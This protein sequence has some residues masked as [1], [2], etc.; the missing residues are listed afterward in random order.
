MIFK[1][2][3]LFI[4][5]TWGFVSPAAI[6]VVTTLPD[7]AWTVK[8][9]GKAHVET[10]SLLTGNEDPHFV[11]ATPSFVSKVAGADVVC[12]V[13]LDLEI[14]WI[15]KVLSRSG[16][17]SVQPGGQGYCEVASSIKTPLEI[18][19]VAVDR[20]MGDVHP[21]GNPHFWLSPPEAI[22]GANAIAASLK[23]ADPSH[24]TEFDEGLK[25][26]QDQLRL[27][28]QSTLTRLSKLTK[29]PLRVLQYHRELTYFLKA[30]GIQDYGSLE[31]LP[32]VLP[33]AGRIATVAKQAKANAIDVLVAGPLAPKSLLQKFTEL[34]GVPHVVVPLSIGSAMDFQELQNTL[35]DRIAQA[36]APAKST[37]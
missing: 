25:S 35:I 7:L 1:R 27:I 11:D 13:G 36:A 26:T 32:G 10:T 14:G 20:S 18:P 9:I 28:H 19:A 31:E 4:S 12:L 30:Y 33:S 29:R 24:T 2:F 6:K 17:A 23:R 37:L 21:R 16:N 8:A 22:E 3:L 5:L 34:S 15:P